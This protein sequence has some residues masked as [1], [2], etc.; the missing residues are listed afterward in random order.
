MLKKFSDEF[1]SV[2]I[3]AWFITIVMILAV[4]VLEANDPTFRM[5]WNDV[6]RTYTS[7]SMIAVLHNAI[8]TAIIFTGLA[9]IISTV[10]RKIC[11]SRKDDSDEDMFEEVEEEF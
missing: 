6:T 9:S 8:M 5:T 7:E 1:N 2:S 10:T 11:V 3:M 4:M